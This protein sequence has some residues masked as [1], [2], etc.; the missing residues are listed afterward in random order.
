MGVER[1]QFHFL[2]VKLSRDFFR[3][4]HKIAF[5]ADAEAGDS[6]L[7][8]DINEAKN[9]IEESFRLIRESADC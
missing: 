8:E 3:L 5:H 1:F 9:L 2:E 4:S 7:I 6:R